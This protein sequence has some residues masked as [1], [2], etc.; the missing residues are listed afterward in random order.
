MTDSYGD[1]WNS[2]ILGI[3]QNNTIVGLIGNTFTTGT[4]SGP[5][6]IIVLSNQPAQIVVAQLG[7]KTN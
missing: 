4:A 3:R 5:I 6:S 7:T 1:G 2:N